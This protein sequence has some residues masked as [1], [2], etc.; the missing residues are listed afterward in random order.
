MS[1]PVRQQHDTSVHAWHF[2]CQLCI[3][4]LKWSLVDFYHSNECSF[5]IQ[6]RH[7]LR[8]LNK[9]TTDC[10]FCL[11]IIIN[12]FMNKYPTKWH[13]NLKSTW[14]GFVQNSWLR[15][16]VQGTDI[17]DYEHSTECH[18]TLTVVCICAY[19]K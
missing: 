5:F 6:G 3:H 11:F 8:R 13:S 19:H 15:L 7:F 17:L 18:R 12:V 14:Y 2:Q 10:Y 9:C 16:S 1:L 4:S